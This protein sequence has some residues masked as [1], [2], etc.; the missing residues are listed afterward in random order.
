MVEAITT[1][2][3]DEVP[4]GAKAS[5]GTCRVSAASTSPVA[6]RA[7]EYISRGWIVIPVKPRSKQPVEDRWPEQR[8]AAEQ[9]PNVFH[10]DRNIGVILGD[11]SGGLVD[12]D[13]DC[14]EAIALAPLFLPATRTFGRSSAPRSH[15]LYQAKHARTERFHYP[16]NGKITTLVELRANKVDDGKGLQTVFPGSIHA[17]TGELIEWENNAELATMQPEPLRKAVASIGVAALLMRHGWEQDDAI[18]FAR[19]PDAAALDWLSAPLYE[20]V[21]RWIGL[22]P[23]TPQPQRQA[24]PAAPQRAQDDNRV[25]RA[26]AYLARIPGAVSGNGGHQQA[27]QAAIAIV[28]GFDLDESSAF[29]LLSSEYNPRCEP[30]WSER[31]L[32]HKVASAAKDARAERGWLLKADRPGYRQGGSHETHRSV[33]GSSENDR[34][35]AVA[36]ADAPPATA[37]SG[38]GEWDPPVE[39]GSFSPPPFPLDSL[40]DVLADFV[41]ELARAT[42]TPPDLGGMLTLAAC[43]AAVAKRAVIEVKPGYREP[44][45]IFAAVVLPPGERK[46]A[47]VR[48]VCAPLIEWEARAAEAAAP[49]ISKAAQRFV[50]S[51]KR[52]DACSNRAARGKTQEERRQA[53]HEMEDL[54]EQH[55]K[56]KIPVEPRL[57]ADDATPEAL[58]SLLALHG[59]RM[60][61]ISDE[62]GVF[63]MMEGGYSDNAKLDVYLKAHA[64][65]E[66]R[67][68]RKGRPSER[69]SDP[70]L[71]LGLAIQPSM[72]EAIA[73]NKQLR[74]V[75]L[76][77]RFLYSLPT[78][79]LG[80]RDV[81]AE[82]MNVSIREGY[83]VALRKLLVMQEAPKPI[84]LQLSPGAY[85]IWSDF[86]KWIEPQLAPFAEFESIRDWA[87]KLAGAV[88]RIAGVLRIFRI[89]S[90]KDLFQN[91]SISI[92]DSELEQAVALGK[93]LVPHALAAFSSMGAAGR[94]D[95]AAKHIL[96]CVKR[97][98]WR[99]FNRRE[100]HQSV[101]R[102][103]AFDEPGRLDQ[104]LSVL[105]DHGFIR[106]LDKPSMRGPGRPSGPWWEVHPSL[107]G[108]TRTPGN[109]LFN[110]QNSADLYTVSQ[111]SA[112]VSMRGRE[113]G[114][115]DD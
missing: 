12:V 58:A 64:G 45:N 37:S 23:R 34:W 40:P 81:D 10:A 108:E 32:R 109:N 24:A 66:I 104:A 106:P 59:G 8:I 22:P 101:R 16:E 25:K 63:R 33:N 67:V 93:Y 56:L 41:R 84:V 100:L 29:Q 69:V 78:S 95:E 36:D 115:D 85:K 42:Q 103:A 87:G 54:A 76:L 110:P 11:I 18:A 4:D 113:P 82:P 28:R 38:G 51:Q 13:L 70:A 89:L 21:A 111:T 96:E 97:K 43:S 61:I 44:L 52:L 77:A 83:S 91:I 46:T 74:G 30:P 86:S 99:Q 2:Q 6:A 105:T 9:A 112:D 62:G 31:E 75:G 55:S 73:A 72:L 98:A 15:W 79:M 7:V 47:V 50:I 49:A 19:S 94:G 14:P 88:A 48:E 80:A 114:E 27:W 68:D 5:V 107:F 39:F 90:L 3:A 102:A 17:D 1:T 35:P 60:A 92:Y 57:L 26:A 65:S 71:T 20:R 53:E